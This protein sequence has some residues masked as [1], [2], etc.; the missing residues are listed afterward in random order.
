M[1]RVRIAVIG[2]GAI[3][4][5][6]H[7]PLLRR[8]ADA[9]EIA[10]IVDLSAQRV[11]D[12]GDRYGVPSEGRLTSID[13][14]LRAAQSG[15]LPVDAAILATSGSHAADVLRLLRGGIRVLAEKPLASSVG[16]AEALDAFAAE[17]GIDLRDWVRIGYMKE[18]DQAS[19]RAREL[20]QDVTLRAVSVEVMHPL[21]DSQ[22]AF[23]RLAA[24]AGDVTPE[25][26]APLL[27]ETDAIVDAVVGAELPGDLRALYTNV[28][29]GSVIHDIALLRMLVGGIGDVRSAEH[30][31]ERMPGSL[32]LR[33]D[34]ASGE[35]PWSIDWHYI[36]RYPD[37]R[38]T[39][40]FHHETGT[41]ELVFGV[42]YVLNLPTILRV[43]ENEP[44]HGICVSETRW[45]QQ[46]AF[47]NELHA[48]AA[49]V[50]GE[51]P[52]GPGV[53]DATADI[54]TAQRML[55]TLAVAEGADIPPSA[56]IQAD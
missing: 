49:L 19:L 36:D 10:A 44:G 15:A 28:L 46:E 6:V 17:A 23:A 43:T 52:D 53:A 51:S 24:P 37:Y 47:E 2:L 34:L 31:G 32:H 20:L 38:E 27:A 25:M 55:R 42:P 39:V 29:L 1:S 18:Y 33:G 56:E 54:R 30:W 12:M 16:E 14:L 9:V 35:A 8:N 22:L 26:L 41:I 45:M 5:S 3:A 21:D 4:Q 13:A 40:T 50:R 11:T 48:L 7:L